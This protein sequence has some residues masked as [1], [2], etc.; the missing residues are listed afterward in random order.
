MPV[1]KSAVSA[2]GEPGGEAAPQ[3]LGRPPR[4]AQAEQPQVHQQ[5]GTAQQGE[6]QQVAGLDHGEEPDG[7]AHGSAEGRLLQPVE[8]LEHRH[9][10]SSGQPAAQLTKSGWGCRS[11]SNQL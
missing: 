8:E 11:Q 6:A 5:H 1:A 7:V 3:R 9:G 10:A 2:A 4:E